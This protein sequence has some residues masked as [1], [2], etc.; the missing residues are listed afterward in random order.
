MKLITTTL[1][2]LFSYSSFAFRNEVECVGLTP[3]RQRILVEIER[4]LGPILDGAVTIYGARG[5]NTRYTRHQIF[6][7][8]RFG[9]RIQYFGDLN[10][11]LEIDLWPDQAPR[12]G[13]TYRG[14]FNNLGGLNCR[15][16]NAR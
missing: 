15:Y 4:G 1:L 2:V 5:E 10:F 14:V 16:P 3:S 11:N 6:Q 13:R 8:R 7:T 12:W 9:N